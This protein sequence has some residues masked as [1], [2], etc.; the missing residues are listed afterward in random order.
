MSTGNGIAFRSSN[1][2][3]CMR[4]NQPQ[5]TT[6]KE[7]NFAAW[8]LENLIKFAKDANFELRMQQEYIKQLRED[9]KFLLNLI[10]ERI[11]NEK[12]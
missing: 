4:V 8:S 3:D 10:R 12:R 1:V 5:K 6:M 11:R 7:T 2:L 9:N